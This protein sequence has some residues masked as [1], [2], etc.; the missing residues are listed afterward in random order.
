MTQNI[1][2]CAFR[3]FNVMERKPK[4]ASLFIPLNYVNDVKESNS[5]FIVTTMNV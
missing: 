2:N 1:V 3:E 5:E 4:L